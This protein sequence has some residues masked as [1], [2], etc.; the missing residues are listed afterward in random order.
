MRG[1]PQ[2]KDMSHTSAGPSSLLCVCVAALA[3]MECER[4]A[5]GS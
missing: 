3:R 5:V 2:K 4:E 1:Q